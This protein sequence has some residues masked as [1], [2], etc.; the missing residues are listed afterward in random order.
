MLRFLQARSSKHS[1]QELLQRYQST[2][3]LA[4]LGQ[5]F[6]RY[7]ELVYGLCLKYLKGEQQ[8]EDASM[9]IFESLV[10]KAREH[11]IHNFKSWLYVV[12]KN[13]CLMQLR[14]ASR[15]PVENTDPALMQFIPGQH[16]T[17]ESPADNGQS[18]H[19]QE[20]LEGLP[21]KQKQCVQAFYLEGYSYQQIAEREGEALGKVRSHIQNGRR[22]LKICMERQAARSELEQQ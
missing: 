18:R 12:A 10:I 16:H 3:E 2:G 13:H 17:L 19:L 8:A 9:A 22:N 15:Q 11:D 21:E 20:C 1:D 4:W 14:Q 6:E 5:L 7:A